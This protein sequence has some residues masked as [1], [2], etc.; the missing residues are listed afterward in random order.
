M[1]EEM[2]F[3]KIKTSEIKEGMR[4]SAPV[5]FDDGKNMFLAEGKTVKAYH[6]NALKRWSIP[7]V[8]TYGCQIKDEFQKVDTNEID[9]LEPVDDIHPVDEF[10]SVG[11]NMTEKG[12]NTAISEKMISESTGNQIDATDLFLSQAVVKKV[13]IA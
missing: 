9:D 10:G 11:R 3:T 4:F 6:I 7:F 1:G 13:C 2:A 8:L 12:L 5:F